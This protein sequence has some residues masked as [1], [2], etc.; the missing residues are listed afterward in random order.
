MV[1]VAVTVFVISDTCSVTVSLYYTLVLPAGILSHLPDALPWLQHDFQL[2][3][4]HR[5]LKK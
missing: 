5:E 2:V 3:W 4:P 1:F